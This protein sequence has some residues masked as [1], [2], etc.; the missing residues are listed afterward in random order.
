MTEHAVDWHTLV[1]CRDGG[2]FEVAVHLTCQV[3]QPRAVVLRGLRDVGAVLRPLVEETVRQVCW[4]FTG[5]R[6]SQAEAAV[7]EAI[8]RRARPA[9][10]TATTEAG[11]GGAPYDPAVRIAQATV[12]L[13]PDADTRAYLRHRKEVELEA[14]LDEHSDQLHARRGLKRAEL[15]QGV[16][17]AR[18][19]ADKILID[20]YEELLS[21]Q[22]YGELALL[23]LEARG[24]VDRVAGILSERRGAKLDHQLRSLEILLQGG[25][26]DP[27]QLAA[28]A[29][30]VLGQLVES[31]APYPAHAAG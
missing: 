4:G 23:L 14:L 2:A 6:G 28:R 17:A 31:L 7:T 8:R 15:D 24:P 29:Q 20:R 12:A 9:E 13:T 26:V 1:P 19:A 30:D 25:V 3:T 21:S 18:V 10:S 5:D 27:G 16:N 22:R 11:G